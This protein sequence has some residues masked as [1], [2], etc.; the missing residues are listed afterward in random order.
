MPEPRP[1]AP[2]NAKLEVGVWLPESERHYVD[3][4]ENSKRARVVEGKRSYKF[5]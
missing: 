2:P 3:W 1:A 4:M 5:H